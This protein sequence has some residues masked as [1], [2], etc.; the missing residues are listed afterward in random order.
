MDNRICYLNTDL[1]LVSR[2]DLL[3]LAHAFEVAGAPPLF[4]TQGED[5]LWHVTIETDE[6]H[7]E[8]EPN[9][10]ELLAIV[11]SLTEPLRGAWW[12]CIRREFNIGY[13]CGAEPWAF[14]Q[15]LSAELLERLAPARASLKFTLYPR[16]DGGMSEKS[17]Q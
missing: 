6:Q 13:E 10:A 17:E 14:H 7:A 1:D 2:E 3:E 4:V 15:G 5:G 9:I 16:R 8:P 12:R 11:E